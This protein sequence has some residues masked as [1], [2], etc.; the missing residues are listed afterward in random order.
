MLLELGLLFAALWAVAFIVFHVTG[1][2]IHV[3]LVVA[4]I[5]CL[6]RFIRG[7]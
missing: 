4:V 2:L 5:V 7:K 6:V 3:L 1:W